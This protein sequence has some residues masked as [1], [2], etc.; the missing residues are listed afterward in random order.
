M[1]NCPFFS[2]VTGMQCK[3]SDL[4][5]ANSKKNVLCERFKIAGNV[6]EKSQYG[7]AFIKV[8]ELLFY[9]LLKKFTHF[10]GDFTHYSQENCCFESFG[11][12]TEKRL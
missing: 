12:F 7:S 9:T 6:P 11:K 2:N 4:T 3:I 10:S 8:T 1:Q 5:K